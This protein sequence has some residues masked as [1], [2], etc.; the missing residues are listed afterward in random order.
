MTRDGRIRRPSLPSVSTLLCRIRVSEAEV[1]R[2]RRALGGLGWSGGGLRSL[3]ATPSVR[4]TLPVDRCC[5]LEHFH[6]VLEVDGV[7]PESLLSEVLE[8]AAVED[9]WLTWSLL[10]RHAGGIDTR[11]LQTRTLPGPDA[12]R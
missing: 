10:A 4:V 2:G 12:Q 11:Q 6:S 9:T 3:C 8:P 5:A 7:G 1:L